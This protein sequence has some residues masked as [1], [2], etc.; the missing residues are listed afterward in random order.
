MQAY[1][2]ASLVLA[3][4]VFFRLGWGMRHSMPKAVQ[5]VHGIPNEAASHRTY[6]WLCRVLTRRRFRG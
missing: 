1:L 5:L 3:V 2:S 4:C 6:C